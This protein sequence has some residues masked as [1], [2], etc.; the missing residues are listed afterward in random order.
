MKYENFQKDPN[1]MKRRLTPLAQRKTLRGANP[2]RKVEVPNSGQT[3]RSW[4]DVSMNKD[5]MQPRYLG[6]V[7]KDRTANPGYKN[8]GNSHLEYLMDNFQ[9]K[10]VTHEIAPV[11]TSRNHGVDDP[12][13]ENA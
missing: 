10:K 11:M 9:N 7:P 4:G 13:M 6:K 8:E 3:E 2:S 1:I 12:F 5:R